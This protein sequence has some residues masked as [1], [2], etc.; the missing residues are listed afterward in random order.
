MA[1]R[2]THDKKLARLRKGLRRTLPAYIDLVDYLVSRRLV[3]GNSRRAAKQAILD[4]KV[5]DESGTRIGR[6]RQ[7]V[8]QVIKG[9]RTMVEMWV[10]IPHVPASMRG[11]IKV[12]A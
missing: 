4:G 2:S 5:T 3:P 12:A 9:K 7:M 11:R 6:T 8:P 10:I 1:H